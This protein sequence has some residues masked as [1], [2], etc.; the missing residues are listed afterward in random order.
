MV[1]PISKYYIAASG[2]W[3]R[4]AADLANAAQ[5]LSVN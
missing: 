3:T 2:L 5:L 4:L 1:E